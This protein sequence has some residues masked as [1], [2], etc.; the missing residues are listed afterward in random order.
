MDPPLH[1]AYRQVFSRHFTP[2][3]IARLSDK[4]ESRAEEIVD[5]VAGAGDIDFVKEVSAKLPML[6]IADLIGIPDDQVEAFAEAGDNFVT[7]QGDPTVAG[8]E[9]VFVYVTRQLK[10]LRHIGLEVVGYRRKHPADDLATAIANAEVDGR[11]LDDDDIAGLMMLLS[12]AGNDT[13]KQ[14]TSHAVV[15]LWQNQEQR[16]LLTKDYDGRIGLAI[17]EFIRWAT[18]VMDFARTA[19]DD[20]DLGGQRIEAGDKVVMFYCSSNRDESLFPDP[21]RFDITRPLMPHQGFGGGGVHFCLGNTVAKAELRALFRQFLTKLP[22]MEVGAPEAMQSDF[23][24]GIRR[25][26][27]RIP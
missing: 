10:T 22:D 11:P 27:V 13:T 8:D 4:L 15:Q 20:V 9:N 1:T 26:P 12:V 24:H 3:A 6:T 17:E 18:P 25:L 23:L 2:K 7:V 19:L 14:T 16:E 5:R 21:H